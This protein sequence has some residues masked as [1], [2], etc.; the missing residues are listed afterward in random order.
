MSGDWPQ[1]QVVLTEAVK[2]SKGDR[3]RFL[4]EACVKRPEL[5]DELLAILETYE[6]ASYL[7]ELAPRDAGTVGALIPTIGSPAH[8]TEPVL[9]PDTPYGPYRVLKQLGAGGMGQVFLAQDV[10]LNRRVAMKSLAGQWLESPTARQRLMREARSA[11][12]V[13]AAP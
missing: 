12:G 9:R 6:T 11:D 4:A 1:T 8:K 5:R 13:T 2:L 10:R 3:R 7:G